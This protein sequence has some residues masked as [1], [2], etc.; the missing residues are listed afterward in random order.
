MDLVSARGQDS[1]GYV[2]PEGMVWIAGGE[3]PIGVAEL[4]LVK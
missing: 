2:P 3:F 1:L 4:P